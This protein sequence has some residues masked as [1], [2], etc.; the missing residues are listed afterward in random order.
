MMI[1]RNWMARWASESLPGNGFHAPEP[2]P[3]VLHGEV[4]G[5]PKRVDGTRITTSPVVGVEGRVV[6][7]ASGSEYRLEEPSPEY[8]AWLAANKIPFDAEHPIRLVSALPRR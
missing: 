2:G 4:Y 6:R 5:H 7:T 3:L 8:M 1:L